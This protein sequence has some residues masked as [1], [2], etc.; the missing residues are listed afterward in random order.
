MAEIIVECNNCGEIIDADDC[1]KED[2]LFYCNK[3]CL[4]LLREDTG[5]Y[6]IKKVKPV[7]NRLVKARKTKK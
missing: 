6:D 5:Y 3:T 4:R 2:G 1:V 7:G